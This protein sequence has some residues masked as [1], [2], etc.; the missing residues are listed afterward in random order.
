MGKKNAEVKDM[1]L[2]ARK[3]THPG[4]M[5]AEEF[6]PDFG[7]SVAQLAARLGVSRQSVNE[8]VRARRAVSPE[9]ALRLARVFGTTPHYWLN[10]QRNVDLWDSLDLHADEIGALEPIPMA[11]AG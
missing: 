2:V 10:M 6:L 1:L 5:L 3:P 9:M 8:L 4:E 7:L 11:A